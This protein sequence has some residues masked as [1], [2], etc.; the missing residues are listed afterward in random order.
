MNKSQ[1]L[2]ETIVNQRNNAL[3]EAATLAAELAEARERIQEL[4]AQLP[5]KEEQPKG[6]EN[7]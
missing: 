6:E 4:E 3:N 5:K 1:A 2:L 7:G